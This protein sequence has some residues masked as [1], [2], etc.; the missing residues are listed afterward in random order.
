MIKKLSIVAILALLLAA[1]GNTGNN[2]GNG[3]NAGNQATAVEAVEVNDQPANNGSDTTLDKVINDEGSSLG[4]EGQ[5]LPDF[6]KF[7]D[8]ITSPI[9]DWDCSGSSAAG[10]LSDADDDGI[11]KNATY[12]IECTKSGFLGVTEAKR[13]GTLT[14]QD[15]DD[16][17]P[18][19]GYTSN[20]SFTYSY[21]LMGQ[22]YSAT[23]EFSRQWT[24][25]AADGY[26]FHHTHSWTWSAAGQS[27]K[28]EHDR[29]GSY[30][31][32]SADDPFASGDLSEEGTIKQSVNGGDLVEVSER[33]NL[34]IK[35]GCTPP[36]DSGSITF[37]YNGTSKTFALD[38]CGSYGPASGQAG[39]AQALELTE[40]GDQ[41]SGSE[42]SEDTAASA[43][44]PFSFVPDLS[45]FD[46]ILG[47]AAAEWDC[48]ASSAS[49]DVSDVDADGIAKNATY[50]I[51]CVKNV[52]LPAP[53][54]QTNVHRTGT[55]TVQDADDNDPT[56]GYNISGNLTYAYSA[57]GQNV[58]ATREF[59]RQ[60]TGN[61]ADGYEF[62]QNQAWTWSAAGQSY[63]VASERAGS[64]DPD[65]QTDPYAAGLLSES[66][67]VKQ[68]VNGALQI[69]VSETTNNLHVN[70]SCSPAADSGS[71]VLSW[72]DQSK[73]ITF[74]GCGEF[75]VQ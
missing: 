10:D 64:Y 21:T 70:E 72:A 48:S 20:G 59:S 27:Y 45:G 30:A 60:W 46:E 56:S 40:D 74:T 63:K 18:H 6:S 41:A 24:G 67:S 55:I 62:T 4:L 28:V 35:D 31:P 16:N 34:H 50:T 7:F 23:R 1:C 57:G 32:D 39:T 2:N 73:T 25:N 68:Y 33:A 54:G 61:A 58:S 3:G 26:G 29:Q 38:G 15:A 52:D 66:G 43:G 51:D 17:D 36:A 49:G 53:I 71:I 12:T 5:F 37:T 14:M 75:Q 9:A 44:A 22:S 65:S 19:S 42:A 8:V 11:A 47:V 13:E 69:T